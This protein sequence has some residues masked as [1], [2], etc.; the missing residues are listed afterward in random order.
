QPYYEDRATGEHMLPWVRLHAIKDYWGMVAL[1]GEFPGVKATFNLVPSLLVQVE[2]FAADRAADRYLAL[3]LKPAEALEPGEQAFLVANGFHAPYGRL[4]RQHPRY[5]E[6]YAKRARGEPFT[7]DE[8]RDLQ[9]L[10][11]L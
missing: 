8:L 9:V 11:K 5:A 3:G 4:I 10:Q 1:L 7:V 6:L 2:A